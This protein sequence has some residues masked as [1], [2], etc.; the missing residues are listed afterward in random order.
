MC[1]F[2]FQATFL[3]IFLGL[4]AFKDMF[5][6]KNWRSHLRNQNPYVAKFTKWSRMLR[7]DPLEGPRGLR[8]FA[9]FL[10]PFGASRQVCYSLPW[11]V[12]F[13]SLHVLGGCEFRAQ[14]SLYG[15]GQNGFDQ[16]KQNLEAFSKLWEELAVADD[17]DRSQTINFCLQYQNSFTCCQ[18]YFIVLDF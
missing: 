14:V 5:W 8:S 6:L 1:I 4:E 13:G 17:A 10:T 18:K 11:R 2:S 7:I 9:N 12:E 15:A 16:L 3:T